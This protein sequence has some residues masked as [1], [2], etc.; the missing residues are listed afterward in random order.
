MLVKP[1]Q[2]SNAY[3][4]MFVTLDGIVML[5]RS[6]QPKNIYEDRLSRVFGNFMLVNPENWNAC[7]PRLTTLLGITISVK[8][9]QFMNAPRS[10]R[11]TP[12]GIVTEA[13]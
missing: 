9:V 13:K 1:V 8:L 2:H 5:V 7:S 11:V 3:A 4:S 12:F 10:M 6:V